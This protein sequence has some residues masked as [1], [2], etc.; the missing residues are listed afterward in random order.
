MDNKIPQKEVPTIPVED[1]ERIVT[2][3][4][5]AKKILESPDFEFLLDYLNKAKESAIL[6]VATNSIKDV[7]ET[8]T[9]PEGSKTYKTTKEEQLNEIAG[10]IKFIDKIFADLK[11]FA[12]Q[13]DEYLKMA[14]ENKLIIEVS[15]EDVRPKV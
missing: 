15:K 6:M 10:C 7:L 2:E 8:V 3:S 1:W 9:Y 5:S 14:E 11:G 4:T 13:E 12:G